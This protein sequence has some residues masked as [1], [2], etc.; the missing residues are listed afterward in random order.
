[1]LLPLLEVIDAVGGSAAPGEIYDRLAAKL[2]IPDD[3]RQATVTVG[4]RHDINA[5]ERRVRWVRQSA[6]VRGLIDKQ[7]RGAWAL[8]SKARAHL[9]EIIRGVVVTVF[10]TSHGFVLWANAEDVAGYIDRGS[11]SL[12]WSSPPYPLLRKREYGNLDERA[13]VDWMLR[14]CEGWRELLTPDGSMMLNLGPCWMPGK[15]QESLYIQRLL[16]K[17]EDQ[18]G[19]SLCQ[20]LSY[21]SPNKMPSPIEWVSVRRCRVKPSVESILWLAND[22]LSCK[23]SNR[24]VL[25]PYSE[26][27]RRAIAHPREEKKR[28]PSGFELG[29]TSFVDNGGSI[30]P[31]LITATNCASASPYRLAERAAGRVPHPATAPEKIIEFGIKLTTDPGDLVFDP[32]FGSGTT[33][34]VSQRLDRRFIGSE[35][36]KTY[37]E[38]ARIRFEAEKLPTKTIAA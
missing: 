3:I 2:E 5:F 16:I 18:L 20:L 23:A 38:S 22:P 32:F 13:W 29:P 9:K 8:T 36:S 24:N 11:V 28:R 15:P 1:M 14:L 33:G 37:I 21:H 10:E 4:D 27:G 34:V 26:S 30:P 7:Q 19:L 31:S 35:R 12:L 25:L 6:V 17:L